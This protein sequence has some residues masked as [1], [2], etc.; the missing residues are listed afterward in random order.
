MD[1]NA[2]R[3]F[4]ETALHFAARSGRPEVAQRLLRRGADPTLRDQN[5][6]T[7]A[8]VAR[9][10][11]RQNEARLKPSAPPAPADVSAVESQRRLVELLERKQG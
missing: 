11:L 3:R 2:R 9:V 8:D 1:V 5:R 6:Q 10:V 4:G 7:P